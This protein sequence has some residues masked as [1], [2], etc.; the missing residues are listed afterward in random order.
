M[1]LFLSYSRHDSAMVDRLREDLEAGGH[2]I[3]L[4]TDDIRGGDR[5]RSSI[6]EAIGEADGVILLIS[7]QSMASENVSRE[8]SVADDLDKPIIPV[9]LESSE[10]PPEFQFLLAG[11]Q[12]IDF[13]LRPYESALAELL[14]VVAGKGSPLPSPSPTTGPRA[15]TR[16]K[17]LR[18]V[19]VGASVIAVLALIATQV[20][21][22]PGTTVTSASATSTAA[23]T[24]VPTTTLAAA[25]TYELGGFAWLAGVKFSP[26]EA[27]HDPIEQTVTVD[28]EVMVTQTETRY[29]PELYSSMLLELPD[30]PQ[31]A[32]QDDDSGEVP[33]GGTTR[34]SF[35]FSGV[36][37]DADLSTATLL[38]G[39]QDEQRWTLPMTPTAVGSGPEPID[40]D[41][42]AGSRVE[43]EG[44]Y[45]EMSSIEMVPW[46]CQHAGDGG[47]K[48]HG[49]SIFAPVS[50]DRFSAVIT[51]RLGAENALHGFNLVDNVTLS[52]PNSLRA[53]SIGN[54]GLYDDGESATEVPMCFLVDTPISGSYTL[55]WSSS[56]GG[57]DTFAFNVP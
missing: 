47:Q 32:V 45:F 18:K 50:H 12:Y 39:R 53:G 13:E 44:L 2:D 51:G 31:I 36:T 25:R 30:K 27:I 57:A 49:T 54:Y 55:N 40:V 16:P 42:D 11:I 3:W 19:A 6:A 23:G 14:Q 7:S 43:A 4:D 29:W 38:F 20:P 41:I 5:W 52:Q 33:G 21:D 34:V 9:R 17:R 8:L 37:P 48:M 22:E 35:S 24:Q 56:H 10:I 26:T 1:K 46:S 15:F 28:Y